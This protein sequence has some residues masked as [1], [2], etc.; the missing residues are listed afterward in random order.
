MKPGPLECFGRQRRVGEV[1]GVDAADD[2]RGE[3]AV[4]GRA[5]DRVGVAAGLRRHGGAPGLLDLGAG[6]AVVTGRPPGSRVGSAPASIGDRVR[7]RGAAPRPA[8]RR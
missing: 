2:E 6:R 7:R 5:Q 1:G 4:D 8:W 3:R